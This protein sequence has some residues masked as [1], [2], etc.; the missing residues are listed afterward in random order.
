M[1]VQIRMYRL[2][3]VIKAAVSVLSGGIG[4]DGTIVTPSRVFGTKNY[5]DFVFDEEEKY[6]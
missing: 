5:N 6:Y 1:T 4:F 2:S 3:L